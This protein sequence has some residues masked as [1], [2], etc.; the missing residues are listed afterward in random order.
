MANRLSEI[1]KWNILLV[2]AGKEPSIILDVPMF[3]SFGVLSEYNWGFKAE[4]EEGAC[5]GMVEGQ[6]RWPRGKC[7][8]G[9]Y[10]K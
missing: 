5:Q 9:E 10:F 8:G 6:C 4:R 1:S 2:E 7:L 3:A